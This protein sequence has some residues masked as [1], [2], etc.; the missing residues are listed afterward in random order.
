[1]ASEAVHAA[2]YRRPS[3]SFPSTEIQAQMP[4]RVQTDDLVQHFLT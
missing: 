1:M 3:A 4:L 2:S